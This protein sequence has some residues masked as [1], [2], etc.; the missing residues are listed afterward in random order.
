M[1][2][3]TVRFAVCCPVLRERILRCPRQ[4]HATP[5]RTSVPA[6]QQRRE[7]NKITNMKTEAETPSTIARRPG[8]DSFRHQS[9]RQSGQGFCMN[10]PTQI[11][12][13]PQPATLPCS[14]QSWRGCLCLCLV[15]NSVRRPICRCV[16]VGISG[17]RSLLLASIARVSMAKAAQGTRRGKRHSVNEWPG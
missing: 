8:F 2:V 14:A 17:S 10:D 3:C 12:Q 13:H 9:F 5:K 15:Y 7:D 1:Y 6:I 4:N 11:C 16:A